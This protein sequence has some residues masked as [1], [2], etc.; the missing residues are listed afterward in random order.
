MMLTMMHKVNM[1]KLQT[2]LITGSLPY[3]LEIVKLDSI[4]PVLGKEFTKNIIYLGF[5]VS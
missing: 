1:H 2:I 3:K 5:V 4:S